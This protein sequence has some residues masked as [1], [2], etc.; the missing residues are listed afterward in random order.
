MTGKRPAQPRHGGARNPPRRSREIRQGGSLTH[1]PTKEKVLQ[2]LSPREIQARVRAGAS[3]E[4]V[5]AETGWPLDRVTRYAEPL[6]GERAYVAKQA[7]AVEISRSRGGATLHES[8]CV[9]L[10]VNP[11]TDAVSWDSYRNP[12][13]RWVVTA[14]H[15]GSAVGSWLFEEVGRSVHP[16]DES[17]RALMGGGP[18][19]VSERTEPDD[20]FEVEQPAHADAIE[21]D[22]QT[23]SAPRPR[24]VSVTSDPTSTE[25]ATKGPAKHT[26]ERDSRGTPADTALFDTPDEPASQSNEP[27]AKRTKRAKGKRGR[28]S[29]P[30]WDEILFGASKTDD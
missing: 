13:G 30:S 15:D 11:E 2:P 10:D 9:R 20:R 25:L 6:L 14:F 5:A 27:P 23:E 7:A 17:A 29:V 18:A 12:E 28:A 8:V 21:Q 1:R 24:L 19:A 22:E 16:Q 4:V 26:A 3:P